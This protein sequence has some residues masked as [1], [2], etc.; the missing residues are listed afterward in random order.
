[1]NMRKVVFALGVLLLAI[2]SVVAWL[3]SSPSRAEILKH[4][5]VEWETNYAAREFGQNWSLLSP[6]FQKIFLFS[7]EEYIRSQL[8]VI[9]ED[10]YV[11]WESRGQLVYEDKYGKHP[12]FVAITRSY[13]KYLRNSGGGFTE[14]CFAQ[15]WVWENS[16]WYVVG[17]W[18]CIGDD[19]KD[20][21][22]LEELAN[23]LRKRY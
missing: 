12:N 2:L 5:A 18:L 19:T 22:I 16:N 6:D 9:P 13:R 15:I 10:V 7:K 23:S 20:M 1:M 11:I 3:V 4:R 21:E 14:G 17:G 8:G